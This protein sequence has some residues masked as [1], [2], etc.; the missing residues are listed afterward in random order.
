MKDSPLKGKTIWLVEDDAM[1]GVTTTLYL[2]HKGAAVES[3]TDPWKA[4]EKFRTVMQ[5]H[6]EPRPDIVITDG[7]YS[8]TPPA[9]PGGERGSQRF[10]ALDAPEEDHPV[11]STITI[12][13]ERIP[14]LPFIVSSGNT[15]RLKNMRL[16]RVTF[17]EKPHPFDDFERATATLCGNVKEI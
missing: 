14:R 8:P 10:R 12:M 6:S 9:A 17:L 16:D 11:K 7:D 15:D 1:V 4:L 2:E 13:R 5:S 3:F